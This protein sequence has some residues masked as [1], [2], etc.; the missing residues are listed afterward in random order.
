M[1]LNISDVDS[2]FLSAQAQVEEWKAEFMQQWMAPVTDLAMYMLFSRIPPEVRDQLKQMDPQG[3]AKFE[4]Q[5]ERMDA[6]KIK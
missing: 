3:Y 6:K 2:S 5:V 1:P 4:A